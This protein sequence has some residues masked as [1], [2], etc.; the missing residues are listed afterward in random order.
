MARVYYNQQSFNNGKLGALMAARDKLVYHTRGCKTLSN[1][2]PSVQGP[3]VKRKG[4]VYVSEL[5]DSSKKARLIKFIFSEIDSYVLEF[6]HNY[7]R[8]S[9]DDDDVF[10]ADKTI[11]NATQADP[12]VVTSTAHG[13]SNGDEI[14]INSVVGM[15]E[16]NDK[17]YLVSNVTA[18]TFELQD[19]DGTDIDGTGYTAYTSGGIAKKVYEIVSPYGETD[20]PSLKYAQLGDIMYIAHPDYRPRKLTRLANTNWTMAEMDNRLGPV[21][22]VNETSTTITLSGTLTE[23]GTSTWT[24]SAATFQSDHVGSVWAIAKHDDTTVIGYARMTSYTSST[25]ADFENQSDLTSVTTT[26]STNWYEASWSGVRGYPRAVAFHESRLFWGG[27]ASSKLT[28]YG[29]VTNGAYEVYDIDDA[30]DDDAL[31]FEI[32]GRIND[33]QWLASNG[34]FLVAGTYGGLAF[35]GSTTLNDAISPTNVKARTGSSFGSSNIQGVQING[36][37]IYSHSNNKSLYKANYDDVTLQY[38]SLDLNDFNPEIL[39]SGISYMDVVEQP[40]S[41]ILTVSN[42]DLDILSYDE[43]QGVE[44]QPLIGWYEYQVDGDIESVATVPTLGD[45]KIWVIVKRT[46]DGTTRRYKEYF[47]ISSNDIYVDSAK[48]YSG[49]ATRTFSG[50][51]HLE[52]KTVSV[53][54]DGSYANDFTVSSGTIT[55]PDDKTA[56]E[57]AYIGLP[58]NADLETMPISTN[59]RLQSSDTSVQT[60]NARYNELQLILYKTIGLQAGFSFDDLITV[61]FRNVN[62]QMTSPPATFGATYPDIKQINFNQTWTRQPTICLRSSLPLPCTILSLTARGEVESQ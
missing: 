2:R 21:E 45:D 38:L 18:N 4:T 55:I 32:S 5:Q 16:L 40:D 51:E 54:G 34:N 15:T 14:E 24:A 44:G 41:A 13:Y 9:Q 6:G 39:S 50:L 36:S 46:I 19:K 42:G 26:A 10:E 28:V 35:I 8:F 62:S 57:D 11:T 47:D 48:T 1:F 60:Y 20:L 43:T 33:I 58:Y 7:I 25:V 12:V 37:I 17:R 56:I 30:S 49:T 31:I 27:T 61:P 29:S 3:A 59:S 22:D 53:W 52:G 23:G